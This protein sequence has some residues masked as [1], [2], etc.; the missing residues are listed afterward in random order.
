MSKVINKDPSQ[1]VSDENLSQDRPREQYRDGET[2]PSETREKGDGQSPPG[3]LPKGWSRPEVRDLL[4]WVFL[5]D[6]EAL[7]RFVFLH[8]F[9]EQ[10]RFGVGFSYKQGV[11]AL[12]ESVEPVAIV[13]AL[14]SDPQYHDAI[15]SWRP[16]RLSLEPSPNF[17]SWMRKL[18]HPLL[19]MLLA[20]A[21]VC[22]LW[23][24]WDWF[25]R[26]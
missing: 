20:A 19:A 1:I 4:N 25:L 26:R 2:W 16:D 9:A 24:L 10:Q 6:D 17:D 8:F 14:R 3:F 21:F 13:E 23:A 22:S 15:A 5:Y 18:S 11:N 7:R 12:L